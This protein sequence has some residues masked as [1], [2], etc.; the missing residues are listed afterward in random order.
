[1]RGVTP[2]ELADANQYVFG[3]LEAI[4]QGEKDMQMCITI[5]QLLNVPWADNTVWLDHMSYHY[6]STYNRWMPTLPIAPTVTTQVPIGTLVPTPTTTGVVPAVAVATDVPST[7]TDENVNMDAP[8]D[9]PGD[10]ME[11]K[12]MAA[13]GGP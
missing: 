3:W 8:P 12:M 9:P 10:S 2:D 11:D 4:Q 6:N 5:N 1:M 13:S 7:L